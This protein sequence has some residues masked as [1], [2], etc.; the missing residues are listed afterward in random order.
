MEEVV[1]GL[2]GDST[3]KLARVALGKRLR[4]VREY[5]GYSQDDV[6]KVLKIHRPSMSCIESGERKID[7]LELVKLAKLYALPV[8]YFLIPSNSEGTMPVGLD[9][10]KLLGLDEE[11]R[12]ELSLFADYLKWRRLTLG[13]DQAS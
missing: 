6:A 11:D 7:S 9:Q 5:L 1:S 4:Q 13:R 2:E 8:D 12:R 3:D 10:A